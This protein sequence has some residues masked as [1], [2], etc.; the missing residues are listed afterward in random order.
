MHVKYFS[1]SWSISLPAMTVPHILVCTNIKIMFLCMLAVYLF[2]PKID[3]LCP[4][5]TVIL[6]TTILSYTVYTMW[7]CA[8]LTSCLT[9]IETMCLSCTIYEIWRVICQNLPIFNYPMCI[10]R[11]H[12]RWPC[13]SFIEMFGARK[14][15]CQGCC[16]ALLAWSWV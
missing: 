16:M 11:P 6:K 14:L 2:S 1:F 9:S 4:D 15:A 5:N 10:W 8:H 7:H 12:W 3:I 13:S